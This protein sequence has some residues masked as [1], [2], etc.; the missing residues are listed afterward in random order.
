MRL[1]VLM[2]SMFLVSGCASANIDVQADVYKERPLADRERQEDRLVEL[3]GSLV[4]ARDDA[5]AIAQSYRELGLA[6]ERIYVDFVALHVAVTSNSVIDKQAVLDESFNSR[7]LAFQTGLDAL[8]Q[9]IHDASAE[10]QLALGDYI[11]ILFDPME[12]GEVRLK[13]LLDAK[14]AYRT[15]VDSFQEAV[16]NL[17]DILAQ[18]AY[19]EGL[20]FLLQQLPLAIVFTQDI[21]LSTEQRNELE[22]IA[23]TVADLA[24]TSMDLANR[25]VRI[26]TSVPANLSAVAGSLREGTVTGIQEAVP[27]LVTNLQTLTGPQSIG[28]SARIGLR[29]IARNQGFYYSQL[30]RLQDAADP[31]WKEV[32]DPANKENWVPIFA[33]T[34]FYA[35]GKAEVVVVRDRPGHY[36]LQRGINNP[37]ALIQGQLEISRSIASATTAVLG[38]VAGVK[39]PLLG[40]DAQ[41]GAASAVPMGNGS[42]ASQKAVVER[43]ARLRATARGSIA[44]ELELFIDELEALAAPVNPIARDRIYERA[45]VVLRAYGELLKFTGGTDP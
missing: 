41:G 36:R 24:Q 9:R 14:V 11:K 4:K 27:T 28:V 44:S 40:T 10:A 38:A 1:F 8:V 45:S 6:T 22:A 33:K 29:D 25:G 23:G 42:L 12:A 17:D 19:G 31:A 37:A 2:L 13:K 15:R 16:S 43:Q 7:R 39:V 26:S 30:D 3:A 32:I 5:V 20:E 34:S 18:S 21:P 35:E